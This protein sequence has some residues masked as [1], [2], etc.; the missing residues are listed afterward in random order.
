MMRHPC[1]TSAFLSSI[2]LCLA[3][4]VSAAHLQVAG[5]GTV[6]RYVVSMVEGPVPRLHVKAFVPIRGDALAMEATRPGDIPEILKEGWP[7]LIKDLRISDEAGRRVETASRSTEGWRLKEIRDGLLN[8]IYDVDYSIAD[9]LGWPAPRETAFKDS[10]HFVFIG[11]SL[12]ITTAEVRSGIVTFELPS[13]WKAVTPWVPVG[14]KRDEFAVDAA[15]DLTANLIILSTTEPR[16]VTTGGFH[17]SFT[18][19]G[20]W[21]SAS[22]EVE[23]VLK[24]V[25]PQFMKMIRHDDSAYYSVV[26]LP[27]QE[28]GGEAFRSSFAMTVDVPPSPSN[29]PMWGHTLAHEIFHYWNGSRLRGADYA[30]SQWFQ[31]GFTEYASDLAMA[32]SGL[33]SSDDFRER[34]A[35][36]IRGYEKLKT[37]LERPGTAK[38][39]PLYSGG[40]LVA[41]CWDVQIRAATGGKQTAADFLGDLWRRTDGG[42]RPY[43]WD[44]IQ[45]SLESTARVDWT[46]F[47]LDHI[48]GSKKL[49][50]AE[51]FS[52]AGLTIARSADSIAVKHDPG[53][54]AGAG[55]VW[56]E[57]VQ[58]R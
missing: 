56:Q 26:L 22:S 23:R 35:H 25:V 4:P 3:L 48:K 16:S 37:P 39:P 18:P 55:S 10:T 13:P 52:R 46:S 40:A 57:I 33:I 44:D 6:A 5:S 29:L 8:L 24:G 12:F 21:L 49:P 42:V 1:N 20:H 50:L 27:M 9:S 43:T 45:A 28:Y 2:V 54:T 7:A 19:M 30:S 14:S 51:V 32:N 17:V 15:K 34:L 36:Y 41:F 38:G 11:R 53:A 31:E 47:Y 58:G